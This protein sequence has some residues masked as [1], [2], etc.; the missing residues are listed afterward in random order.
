MAKAKGVLG[1]IGRW[2]H[3][4]NRRRYGVYINWPQNIGYGLYLPHPQGI[5]LNVTAKIGNNVTIHRG[6]NI[7]SE[8]YNAATIGNNVY[9]GPNVCIVE[10]VRIGN[11]VTIGAGAVVVK[12]VPDGAVVAGNPA[13]IISW[14]DHSDLHRNPWKW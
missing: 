4:N 8:H 10:H 12:D 3:Y 14:K 9:I 5:V 13:R 1:L 11:N 7:G 6:V 2:R